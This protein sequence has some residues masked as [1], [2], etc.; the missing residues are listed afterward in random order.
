MEEI[1]WKRRTRRCAVNLFVIASLEIIQDFLLFLF[2]SESRGKVARLK[3]FENS[4]KRETGV[5]LF[6][7]THSA[8]KNSIF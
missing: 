4:F 5:L 8:Y 1:I 3:I 6:L 7:G 2:C